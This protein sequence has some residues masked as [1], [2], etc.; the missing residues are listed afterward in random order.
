M[1]Q[2]RWIELLSDYD[3]EIHYHPGRLWL[4][5][6]GGIRDMV[7]HESHKSKYSIHPGSDKMYQ[8]LKKFYWWPNMK[9]GIATF[10]S[11]SLTCA[12]VIVDRLTKSAHFLLMKKTDSIEKLAQLYLKGIVCRHGVPVSIISDRDKMDGQSE[13]TIQTL[14][15]MLR[16]CAI[17]FGNS[18]DRHLPLVE[19]SYN[20]SYHASIK[21]HSM[22]EKKI[23]QIKN[24]LLTARSR[25]KSYANVRR[26]PI[27]FEVGDKVML[28]VSPWNG[29]I[30]FR[31]H[32]KLS[33]RYIGPFKIIER[34][35]P[36]AYKLELPEKLRG[37]HNTFH[38]SNL[39]K[40]LA[41]DNLVIPLE[42]V[43]LDD[44]LHFMEEP[45]E[46]MDREVKQLKQVEF[47]LLKFDEIRDAVLNIL[48]NEKISSRETTL[49]CS[50]EVRK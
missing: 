8:D 36:V 32:G 43:Q 6:F 25:Q 12:K 42:E 44:K 3:C 20:N 24:R 19:F 48:G 35:G 14:E 11:K 47:P 26:N 16:A 37:I 34:I 15:D 50:H 33:P 23:V 31:K 49:T 45:V 22:G 40:C 30:R 38:V 5:L 4:P 10:V 9:A 28:K 21:A 1:R 41:D 46:I 18:W 17:D 39:K 13:R 2:R 7:M 29:V 27:E